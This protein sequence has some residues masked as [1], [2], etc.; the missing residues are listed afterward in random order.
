MTLLLQSLP[1]FGLI[2]LLGSGRVAAVPAC[3][4]AL[5]LTLP[6]AWLAA[7]GSCPA[8]LAAETV[9]AAWLAAPAM[10]I[11]AGGLL[12]HAAVAQPGAAPETVADPSDSMFTAAFLLGPF[13][14]SVTGF[15]VGSIFA[16]AA[17]QRAGARGPVAASIGLLS[18]SLVPWGGLGPGSALGAA[19]ADVPV[20]PML[21][22]NAVQA[23]AFLLCLLP[24]FW[25]WAGM[26]GV[27][28]GWQRRAGQALWVAA[29]AGLI[30]LWSRTL[31]WELASLLA[32]GPLLLLK[33]WLAAPPRDAVA[34]RRTFGGIAPYA[35]LVGTILGARLWTAPAWR[36]YLDLPAFP[37]NHVAVA[38]WAAASVLLMV[39]RDRMGIARA[40]LVRARGPALAILLFVALARWLAAAEV[41]TALAQALAGAFGPLA[42]Y[43]SPLLAIISGF[44]AGSNVGSNSMLMPMQATLGRMAGLSQTLLPAVQNFTGAAATMYAPQLVSAYGS[45]AGAR[46][47]AIWR[48]AWPVYVIAAAIGAAS[49]A[50]G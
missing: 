37:L 15:G 45:L 43:A 38:L 19:L 17:V 20:Q 30:V 47:G 3:L 9:R 44:V 5:V 23:G 49:V 13:A 11:V 29:V 14:K 39:R 7:G 41:P 28:I 16:I 36:P 18:L 1:L 4:I 40:A 6:A 48:L 26:A 24:V 25:W 42:L 22:R 50:L 10:A 33:L 21:A 27:W 8:V 2:L 46:P 35:L 34:W 32:T 12:F 31:P